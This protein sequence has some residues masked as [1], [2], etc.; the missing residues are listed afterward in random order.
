MTMRRRP[1]RSIA[2][3]LA[4]LIFSLTAPLAGGVPSGALD[5][6][7]EGIGREC[8]IGFPAAGPSCRSAAFASAVPLAEAI[9]SVWSRVVERSGADRSGAH[10]IGAI[11]VGAPPRAPVV[12][13]GDHP[14][15]VASS[16][17]GAPAAG[18]AARP[19]PI[20]S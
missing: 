2:V 14:L 18:R 1:R 17:R 13:T 5:R 8:G 11:P 7:V 12:W 16:Q 19:P 4:T 20:A 15:A 3:V 10:P 9:G 6:A